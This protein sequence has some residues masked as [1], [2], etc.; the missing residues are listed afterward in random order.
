MLGDLI[1]FH[2]HVEALLIPVDQLLERRRQLAIG[3]DD[4]DELADVERAAQGEIAADRVEEER[5]HLCQE[6]VEE[7]DRELAVDRSGSGSRRGEEAVGR[8]PPA[9]S[10]RL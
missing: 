3:G 9:P 4:G 8:S 6:V 1:V 10:S 2:L 5:R 7:F